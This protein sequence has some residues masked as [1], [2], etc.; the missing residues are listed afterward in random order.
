MAAKLLSA[1]TA[2]GAS[3]SY[4][5]SRGAPTLVQEHTVQATITG[6]PT[7]VTIAL[8]ASL[9]NGVS[10][11]ALGTYAFV[12]ADLTAG[13]AMFHVVNKPAELVRLNLTVL[14]GGTAPT[15]TGYY[16]P[17]GRRGA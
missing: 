13:F 5:L 12:A 8:E 10:W 4:V 2:T 11:N 17:F 7:A 3:S 6:A 9:D 1:A 14:T 16:L 15:V